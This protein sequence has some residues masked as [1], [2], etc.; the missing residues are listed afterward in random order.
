MNNWCRCWL[1]TGTLLWILNLKGCLRDVFISGLA[2][3]GEFGNLRVN[4]GNVLPC[5]I[6]QLNF[7]FLCLVDEYHVKYSFQYYARFHVTAVR[8]GT[9]LYIYIYIYIYISS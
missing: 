4:V 3:D 8:L 6:Y 2:L 9:H 7:N 5:V 1:S